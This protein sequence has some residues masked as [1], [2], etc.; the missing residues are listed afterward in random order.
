MTLKVLETR[1]G[2]GRVGGRQGPGSSSW[3]SRIAMESKQDAGKV[4]EDESAALERNRV[5]CSRGRGGGWRG[6]VLSGERSQ[7]VLP[8]LPHEEQ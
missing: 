7:S 5:V 2:V 1:S 6:G 3:L 4:K 8:G